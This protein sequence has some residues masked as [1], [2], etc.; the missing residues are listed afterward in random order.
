VTDIGSFSIM[1]HPVWCLIVV[2][3]RLSVSNFSALDFYNDSVVDAN[4]HS[5]AGA[6]A[7]LTYR[8][9]MC[10]YV[11]VCVCARAR[12]YTHIHTSSHR[13]ERKIGREEEERGGEQE[14][15][16]RE[17]EERGRNKGEK[18]RAGRG[19]ERAG[20]ER[21]RGEGIYIYII[22]IHI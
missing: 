1:L 6:K 15:R 18:E 16:G 13:G 10:V 4:R 14:E 7:N 11:C 5:Y 2:G 8:H 19:R 9:H 21:E 3:A 17:Q 12:T 22:Y 20:R